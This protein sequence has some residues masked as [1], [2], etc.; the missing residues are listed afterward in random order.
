MVRR[1]A[2]IGSYIDQCFVVYKDI[3]QEEAGDTYTHTFI[4]DPWPYCETRWFYFWGTVSGEL[5]PSVSA[6]F[7]KHRTEPNL[8]TE[9]TDQ[10]IF[11]YSAFYSYL[12]R[13]ITQTVTPDHVYDPVWL[14]LRIA[15]PA[16][17]PWQGNLKIDITQVDGYTYPTEPVLWAIILDN[18]LL[19]LQNSFAWYRCFPTGVTLDPAHTHRIRVYP[20]GDWF[21]WYNN[22]WNPG[23]Q[24][25]AVVWYGS[26]SSEY[27]R[28]QA[29][30]CNAPGSGSCTS[31]PDYY[32]ENFIF[33]EIK[34]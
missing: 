8:P 20:I 25:A 6:I 1:G 14:D 15:K 11:L 30:L 17:F 18:T 5:S 21:F 13:I 28:G 31:Q 24:W 2:Q 16:D 22:K 3:E 9:T 4:Q 23:N 34:P 33:W 10:C 26:N 32:D 29:Y 27:P 12:G 19:P 7:E